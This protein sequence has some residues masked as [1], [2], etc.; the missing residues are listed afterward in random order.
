MVIEDLHWG[1]AATL[2]LLAYFGSRIGRMRIL[3]LA[4]FRPDDLH[5]GHPAAAAIEKVDRS[6]HAGRI[7]LTGLQGL[8]L[9]TFIDEALREFRW[10]PS[11]AGRSRLQAK[12]IRFSP[13]SC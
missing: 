10:T 3:L 9:R 8:E 13:E 6:A 11:A 7:D 2:D 12:A 1:D 5:A 4:S